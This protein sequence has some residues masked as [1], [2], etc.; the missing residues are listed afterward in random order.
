[1]ATVY[2]NVGN[3]GIPLV[4]LAFPEPFILHQSVITS[5]MTM[6]IVSVGAWMLAPSR[7]ER[8]SWRGSKSRSRHRWCRR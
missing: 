6:L 5:M 4:K 2:A 1:M 7:G 8:V 3:Y